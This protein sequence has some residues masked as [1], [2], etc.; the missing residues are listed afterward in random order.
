MDFKYYVVKKNSKSIELSISITQI[1]FPI[2][3]GKAIINKM[4]R[5]PTDGNRERYL[6]IRLEKHAC[7]DKESFVYN[8]LVNC[9]NYEH[10]KSIFCSNNDLFNLG[11]INLHSVLQHIEI[12]N[13]AIIWIIL[14]IKHALN[15]NI[16]THG[17]HKQE[18]SDNLSICV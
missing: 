5:T 6:Y 10:V 13:L 4:L 1:G 15:I 14:L 17:K 12:I 11:K 8:Q 18:V 3:I 9:S 7:S 2:W 16:K